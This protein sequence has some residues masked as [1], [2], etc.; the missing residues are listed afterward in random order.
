MAEMNM[1]HAINDALSIAMTADERM[2]VFG[3]DV[4]HFG[5][6]FRATSGL[7]EKFGRDRCFNTP[8]TEQG[9]AGFANGLASN[10]MTAVAEIQFAD[11]IFPAFDQI[12]NESAK[13]RYRSGNQFDVGGLTFR[14]PY[15]GGIAGGHYH[16]QSPEA[17]FTQ[18]PGLKVVIPRNPEQAKG[19]LL[20]SIRD[21]NPIIFF[22]PKRLYRA[23]VGEVPA[24]DYEIE[25]GKAEVVKSGTDITLLGWGA[26]MEIL[27]KAA[28]MAEKEG[29]SSEII[30]LRTLAPWDIETVAASVKKTGRLLINHEAPL[31]GGFAGE[32]A[33]TIQ[34]ECF[35][36]LESPI[37]RVC[38]LDTPYPLILEK[39]YM[40]DELKTFEAI[41]AS[42]NF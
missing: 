10:G 27:E 3:E 4:G 17:Y 25:L 8:L 33:A 32:I 42:V 11:Y 12:V 14:T 13:F 30:D 1:L 18:T 15:G 2:V 22:E 29:I 21:P 19:L 26:Q 37:S 36:S 39:E 6:V 41:K 16:S 34:Q 5:G 38:G 7:Q 24:G 31:T 20:A 9:I 28:L 35:L 40:P 23:S